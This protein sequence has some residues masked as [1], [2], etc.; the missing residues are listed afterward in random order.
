ME[1]DSGLLQGHETSSVN[2]LHRPIKEIASV[3]YFYEDKMFAIQCSEIISLSITNLQCFQKPDWHGTN[4]SLGPLVIYNNGRGR[5][6]LPG[7]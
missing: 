2:L 4:I 6:N 7:Q 3:L 1:P 5:L